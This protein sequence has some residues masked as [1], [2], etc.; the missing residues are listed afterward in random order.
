MSTLLDSSVPDW[1]VTMPKVE[2]HVHLEG[3]LNPATLLTLARRYDVDL[4]IGD[5]QPVDSLFK[6]G[7][8]T[9]FIE[10]F[11]MCSDCL[12]TA[13]D[14]G[15]AV[16][17]YAVDLSRQGVRYA[18]LHFNPE[19]HLRRRSI[20]MADALEHMNAARER[21]RLRD[22]LELRW[23]ADGVRDAASGPVSADR[24]V[25]WKIDAG[26]DSGI[27]ALGLGGNEVGNPAGT[28][29]P[30]FERAR[31]AGFHV[32]AHAGE[33]AGPESIRDAIELLG[34]E[35]I[36][37]G[38]VAARDPALM[39]ML[40]ERRIPLEI[41]PTSN[42][43]TGVIASDELL[44]LETFLKAGVRFSIN[45]DDPPMFETSLVSEY[46]LVTSLL[47]LDRRQVATIVAD[48]INQ[49]FADDSTKARLLRELRDH[50]PF[51]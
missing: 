32:V 19:P 34:A 10:T 13:A 45:S 51:D 30:A 5:E 2:L 28:F 23:I 24:T 43:R 22:G 42:L 39:T 38:I 17:A 40:R 1:L 33:A 21:A 11:T 6:Y 9:E 29:A 27:V 16:D 26:H 47:D 41:C 7:N 15:Q 31:R 36:G 25:D 3:T 37:H 46:A 18:E 48:T 20:A 14:L 44:P 49:S 8:F 50:T 35:R 4:G 12:R